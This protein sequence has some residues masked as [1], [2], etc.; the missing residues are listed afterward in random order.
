MLDLM[1]SLGEI[2]IPQ[3]Q[4]PRPNYVPKSKYLKSDLPTMVSTTTLDL[5]MLPYDIYA[6]E[7]RKEVQETQMEQE[8]QIKQ[9][10][11]MEHEPQVETQV[12]QETLQNIAE[13]DNLPYANPHV[14]LA[15]H[16]FGKTK[17][18]FDIARHRYTLMLDLSAKHHTDVMEMLQRFHTICA[19]Q[20]IC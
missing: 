15:G 6:T 10:T 1:H 20:V 4:Y 8:I 14:F 13:C 19:Q 11:Q 3:I 2:E 18:L 5:R 7:E 16:A 9:E 12:V 17:S